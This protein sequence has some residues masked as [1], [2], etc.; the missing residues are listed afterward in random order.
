MPQLI[1][2]PTRVEAAGTL[3]KLIDEYVGCVNSGNTNVS[4]AHMR[5]PGSWLEPGQRPEFDEFTVV[6]K[7]LLRVEFEGGTL[8]VEAGQEVS[9][10]LC[11][12][13]S[14]CVCILR[15]VPENRLLAH[16]A[17]AARRES[18]LPERR[19]ARKGARFWRGVSGPLCASTVLAPTA[20]STGGAGGVSGSSCW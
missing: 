10:I 11:K 20:I 7:G 12:R 13:F 1:A 3:P 6:L 5:S 8:D 14:G 18:I 4:I 15:S 2:A 17:G 16:P 9:A 19:A